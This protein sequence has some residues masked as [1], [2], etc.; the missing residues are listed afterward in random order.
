MS[1]HPFDLA[2]IC[3]IRSAG[4]RCRSPQ[5]TRR[6]FPMFMPPA[7]R[8]RLGSTR[9]LRHEMPDHAGDRPILPL[10]FPLD[11]FAQLRRQWHAHLSLTLHASLHNPVDRMT[12]EVF[13]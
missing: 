9:R 13:R 4:R 1:I 6:P 8:A 11:E 3:L 2:I 12:G 5:E 10:S 7:P